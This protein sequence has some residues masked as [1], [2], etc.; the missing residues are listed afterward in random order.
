MV[1]QQSIETHPLR[2]KDLSCRLDK[3]FLLCGFPLF[4]FLF[5]CGSILNCSLAKKPADFYTAPAT[6]KISGGICLNASKAETCL[7]TATLLMGR[8]SVRGA[9]GFSLY[10]G[11][12]FLT[13]TRSVCAFPDHP[14][15]VLVPN[16]LRTTYVP[17]ELLYLVEQLPY[18]DLLTLI[19]YD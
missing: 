8:R 1:E 18:C 14:I 3:S 11:F 13:R 15:I 6:S 16:H 12:G 5:T 2:P 4:F 19:L 17:V 10:P 9:I 7:D